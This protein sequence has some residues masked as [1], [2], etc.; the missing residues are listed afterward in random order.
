MLRPGERT[1]QDGVVSQGQRQGRSSSLVRSGF[2]TTM[3]AILRSSTRLFYSDT[4]GS[5]TLGAM[6][7][8]PKEGSTPGI[9]GKAVLKLENVLSAMLIDVAV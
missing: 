6:C 4:G 8:I 5:Y 7:N 3:F 9:G 2:V 1:L